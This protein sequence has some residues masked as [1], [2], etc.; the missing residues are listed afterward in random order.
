MTR[1]SD[2]HERYS[3]QIML[4]EIG[5]EGQRILGN[6]AVL[7]VG[8]GGLGCPVS[9]YLAGAGIGRIGLA[10]HDTVSESN[11]HRQLLYDRGNIG[12]PKAGAARER[13]SRIAP[14]TRFECH[15]D[16][17]SAENAREIISGYDLVV[18]C[19][20]N[21]AT[22]YLLDDICH[23][24]SRPWIFGAIAS[25]SGML[26]LF[27]PGE[28]R[29]RDLFTDRDELEAAPPASGGVIGPT[30]GV[31]GAMQAAEAIKYLCG[32]PCTLAGKLFSINLLDFKT[33]IINIKE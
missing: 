19:S 31:I 15:Y 33:T 12:K 21:Y 32:I 25:F 5:M 24:L 1:T 13:L 18:D 27:I 4:P 7:I 16:G 8:L 9:L 20:D 30:P 6:S 22:R 3:R 29:F 28:C 10:D 14:D 17:L 11:L 26:S 23:E 2:L